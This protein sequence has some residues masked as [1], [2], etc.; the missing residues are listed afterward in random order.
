MYHDEVYRSKIKK[1]KKIRRKKEKNVRKGLECYDVLKIKECVS[2]INV[3][4]VCLSYV[5]V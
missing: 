5:Y 3:T 1:E 4:F 2:S